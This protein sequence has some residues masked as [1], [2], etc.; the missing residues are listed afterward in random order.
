MSMSTGRPSEINVTPLIDV[1]LV[2]LVI[3][4]V[5]TP[6]V[7]K[8]EQVQLPPKLPGVNPELP[9]VIVTLHADLSVEIDDQPAAGIAQL[10]VQLRPKLRFAK[11]VFVDFDDGVPWA[12][13]VS[14]VDATRGLATDPDHDG[15]PIAVRMRGQDLE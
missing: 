5:I 7:I 14:T 1:L 12:S 4:M 15:V 6:A 2:L 11:A 8:L 9:P 3:F 10:A 13:V